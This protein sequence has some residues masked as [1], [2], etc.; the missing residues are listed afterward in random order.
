MVKVSV[1]MPVYNCEDFLQV[2]AESILNQTLSD[3]EL[4]CVDDG[5]TDSSLNILKDYEKHDS[6]VKVF[7]LSHLGGGDARNFA[8]NHINGEYLYFMDADDILDLNAFEDFYAIS[9]SKNLDFLIFKAKKYDVIQKTLFETDYYNMVPLSKF[10]DKVFNFKDLNNLIFNI[11]VTPWCK[12]YNTKFVLDSGA[13]FRSAS[14]FNDNQFFWDIIFQAERIYFLDEFYYTQNV[15]PNSLIESAGKSH[16]DKVDVLNN[17]WELFKKQGQFDKFKQQLYKNKVAS[18]VRRYD[19]IKDEFKELFFKKI[20]NDL[21]NIKDGKFRDYLDW[22]RKFAFDSVMISKNHDD[23]DRLKEFYYILRNDSS[24]INQKMN[25]SIEWFDKLSNSHKRFAFNYIR[26]YFIDHELTSKG[27]EFLN[28]FQYDISII[29]PVFNVENYLEDAFNSILNQTFGFDNLEIIFVDDAST[30]RS[31]QIIKEYSDK[32]ENVISIFLDK[33]SGYAGLPRNIGMYYA[34]APYLM[35][36]DPDDV[37]IDD[38]CEILYNQIAFDNLDVVCGVHSDGESVP[39]W[40]LLNVLTDCQES[41]DIR[42]KKYKD[43][44][45]DSSFELKID[46]IEEYPSVIAAANIWDKIFK[47]S[48]IEDNNVRFPE[49]IPAE[50]SVFLVDA[51]LNAH[52]IKFI[53]KIIVRHDYGRVDSVQH[54]FSKSKIIKRIKAYYMMFYLFMDKNKTDIFKHYLLVRKLRHVLVDHIM[55]CNLSTSDFLEILMYIKPLF[56]L[57]CDYGG[58]IPE[59]LY[60]F[61]DIAGGDFEKALMFIQGE[62]TPKLADVKCINSTDYPIEHCVDLS[63][64]WIEQFENTNPDLFIFDEANKN[65]DILDYCG[66]H[67]VQIVCIDSYENLK[68]I[69]DSINFKYIPDLKHLVLIYR[70]DDLKNL[71][72]ITNHFYSINYPFKHLKM[73]TNENNLFLSDTILESDLNSL[74]FGDNYYYCFADLDFKFDENAFDNEY[75]KFKDFK[76]DDAQVIYSFQNT[77]LSTEIDLSYMRPLKRQKV[78][79]KFNAFRHRDE[80]SAASYDDAI[81]LPGNNRK[82]GVI[83]CNG[84]LVEE[85]TSAW[86]GGAYGVD[87]QT[88]EHDERTVVFLGEYATSTWGHAHV[89]L[90]VR[91]W[92]CLSQ[93]ENIDAYVIICEHPGQKFDNRP[94]NDFIRMAGLE[95]KVIFIDRPTR[96][97]KVIVPEPSFTRDWYSNQFWKTMEVIKQNA[98]KESL[99]S[100]ETP[101]KIFL[102]RS[103]FKRAK[104]AEGGLELLD[105]YFE[106][107]G[108][109][110]IYPEEISLVQMVRIMQNAKVCASESGSITFNTMFANDDLNVIVIERIPLLADGNLL[111]NLAPAKRIT[112]V[113]GCYIL[114]PGGVGGACMLGFTDEFERFTNDNG[115]CGPSSSYLEAD[116]KNKCL[117]IYQKRYDKMNT[118]N[119]WL[120]WNKPDWLPVVYE[121]FLASIDHFPQLDRKEIIEKYYLDM[122]QG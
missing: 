26:T 40:I 67:N 66:E 83:D 59:N 74:D 39:D 48:F 90:L 20:K 120:N 60:V 35:F 34:T 36:L 31:P 62:N 102:S 63:D 53:N 72:D 8:L 70:L 9:K 2:S 65:Q 45:K 61:E 116:Y 113:D 52:G 55:K 115:Y 99:D 92:Y 69:L 33:N 57:Y 50:D 19:E 24:D 47:R 75:K 25:Q 87:D 108:F 100:V 27:Q 107:N 51:F 1:I 121:A 77:S 104:S 58:L 6:R 91:F 106:K 98:L 5:S 96:F 56:K 38:A 11:S 23:F 73:I 84:Q 32:Y 68:T 109:T 78:Q 94:L 105:D 86:F 64:D 122:V 49:A 17:I 30:D 85:S 79:E 46:F 97:K 112:Y 15:H 119:R 103:H 111:T 42:F 95:E 80:L 22:A 88:I 21:K 18:Y 37:F 82:G 117:E 7:S 41:S 76:S 118:Y 114:Y 89:S 12:F 93:N 54:Q 10:K 81:V 71:N 29:I 4:I 16:C 110:I 13:K 14:K 44:V 28:K 43:M 3:L 101:E